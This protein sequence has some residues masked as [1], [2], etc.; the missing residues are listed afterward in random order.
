ME[1]SQAE[2]KRLRSGEKAVN[3]E[4]LADLES[5]KSELLA[6]RASYDEMKMRLEACKAKL[7]ESHEATERRNAEALSLEM[8]RA[9]EQEETNKQLGAVNMT[10]KELQKEHKGKT[11][12][13]KAVREASPH[14]HYF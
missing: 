8:T 4:Q 11:I 14:F 10:L 9:K 7:S 1:E 6:A 3:S 2:V 12:Q 5:A 13:N